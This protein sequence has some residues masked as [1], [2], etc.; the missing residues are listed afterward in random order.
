[1]PEW[2]LGAGRMLDDL[3]YVDLFG[4]R[5]AAEAASLV[6]TIHGVMGEKRMSSAAALQAVE[7]VTSSDRVDLI[8]RLTKEMLLDPQRRI[9]LDELVA[10]EVHRVLAVLQD[11]DQV[12]GLS[13]SNDETLLELAQRSRDMFALVAPFCA[14]LQ[15]A[16][17]WGSPAALRPWAGGI[18]SFVSAAD[19][20][21]GG[22]EALLALR[23]LPGVAAIMTAGIACV[24]NGTWANMH[25][26]LDQQIRSNRYPQQRTLLD[27]S[28]PYAPFAVEAVPNLLVHAMR[29]DQTLD[30]ALADMNSRRQK[31][32]VP[33][34]QWL[35]HMLRPVFADQFPDPDAYEQ[36]FDRAEAMLGIVSTDLIDTWVASA[37][38]DERRWAR[39]HWF[40]RSTWRSSHYRVDPVGDFAAELTARGDGWGVCPRSG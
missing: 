30:E 19:K 18:K 35:H 34:A 28:D 21:A 15:V 37:P 11:E 2:D 13:G 33:V 4:A 25:A 16:A 26:L 22:N 31:Y 7:Q 3:N 20:I 17:R 9:E 5:H 6:T 8:R 39:S 24:S 23:H 40:G 29:N 1:M 14:S 10:Q 38:K 12:K 36:E 27:V 32:Y